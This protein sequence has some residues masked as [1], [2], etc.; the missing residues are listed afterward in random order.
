MDEESGEDYN[1]SE[2][3]LQVSLHHSWG[4]A[5]IHTGALQLWRRIKTIA[6]RLNACGV[7]IACTMWWSRVD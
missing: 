4:Q 5:V 6:D 7:G 2:L 1:D 3:K